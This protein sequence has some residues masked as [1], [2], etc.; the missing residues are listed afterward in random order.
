MPTR[1]R[2]RPRWARPAP[3]GPGRSD[4]LALHPAPLTLGQ[5]TPDAK[6]LV[7]LQ[8]VLQALHA[9][10]T[11]PADLLGLPG[12]AALL[13]EES[14]RI[15]LCAQRAILPAR[16]GGVVNTDPEPD[17]LQRD[18]DVCHRAPPT[19]SMPVPSPPGHGNYTYEITPACLALSQAG[20]VVEAV[21][22]TLMTGK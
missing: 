18:D 19:P 11:A 6:A 16:F 22:L 21:F 17:G 4:R 14:L 1:R 5:P 7:M 15:R 3:A 8:R 13:R 12:G 9:D 2:A 10:L 20:Y